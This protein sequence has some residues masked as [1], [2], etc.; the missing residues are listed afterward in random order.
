[1]TP[2]STTT[3]ASSQLAPAFMTSVLMD[4]KEVMRR[5]LAM[6]VSISNHGAWHTAAT[7]FFALEMS[8]ISWRALARRA[9]DRG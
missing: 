2:W 6:P 8:F 5:P 3:S 7:T 4:L 9:G 1:M